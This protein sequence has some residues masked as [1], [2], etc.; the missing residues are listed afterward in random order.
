MP[1]PDNK[2]AI[3]LG[4]RFSFRQFRYFQPLRF[5]KEN[6]TVHEKNSLPISL[7]DMHM[8]RLMV[9]A[10]EEKYETVFFEDSGHM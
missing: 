5:P 10:I 7:P 6:L 4:K 8:N 2:L 9:V 1:T 3:F